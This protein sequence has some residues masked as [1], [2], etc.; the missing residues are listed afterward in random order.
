MFDESLELRLEIFTGSDPEGPVVVPFVRRE[1]ERIGLPEPA[2]TDDTLGMFASHLFAA[3]CRSLRGEALT[4][5]SADD[6]ID[7]AL[8]ERPEALPASQAMAQRAVDELGAELPHTEIRILA[9]HFAT[10][11]AQHPQ[12]NQ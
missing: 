4:E 2:R 6:V 7:A 5:F 3:L 10:L 8:A 11:M 12:E 9:L 1:L